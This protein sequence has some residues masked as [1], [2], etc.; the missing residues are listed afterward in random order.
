MGVPE[1]FYAPPRLYGTVLPEEQAQK[2]AVSWS[3][4]PNNVLELIASL[5][6]MVA[7]GGFN[8]QLGARPVPVYTGLS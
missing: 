2:Q 1:Y 5:S 6:S 4:M 7:V 8:T 3:I